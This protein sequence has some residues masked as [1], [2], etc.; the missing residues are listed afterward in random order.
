MKALIDGDR[1]KVL[2]DGEVIRLAYS[3]LL[4]GRHAEPYLRNYKQIKMKQT[5][6]SNG[7]K[8]VG[9]VC[10]GKK[11]T[12]L[13]HRLVAEFHI[14]NPN[15]LE[16]VNHKDLDKTNNHVDNLEWVSRKENLQHAWDN[17]R[18]RIGSDVGTSILGEDDVIEI[19]NRLLQGESQTAIANS[20]D[21]SNYAIH[22]IAKGKNWGWLTG[23]KVGEECVR[24]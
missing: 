17:G 16:E 22:Q 21:V 20:Y 6:A 13:V 4:H 8:Y 11:Y 12:F 3:E 15:K 1:Y 7:Y 24:S 2:P 18:K 9:L 23:R 14:P 10:N 19:N 5:T